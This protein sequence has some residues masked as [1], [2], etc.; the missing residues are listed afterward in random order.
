MSS[1][2]EATPSILTPE[3]RAEFGRLARSSKT[4]HRKQWDQAELSGEALARHRSSSLNAI[5]TLLSAVSSVDRHA[6][7]N[8]AAHVHLSSGRAVRPSGSTP[9]LRRSQSR[10]R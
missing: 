2:G 6:R 1:L 3:E 5:F 4:E 7:N 8:A 9:A 10:T